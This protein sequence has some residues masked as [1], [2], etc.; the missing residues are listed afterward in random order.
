MASVLDGWRDLR[1]EIEATVPA[2]QQI[3]TIHRIVR[4][5]VEQMAESVRKMREEEIQAA[6]QMAQDAH[7]I[8]GRGDAFIDALSDG[9]ITGEE[10]GN[11]Q[12][13][14]ALLT[15]SGG[16]FGQDNALAGGVSVTGGGGGGPS[17]NPS[18]P[19]S[20]RIPSTDDAINNQTG[21]VSGWLSGIF[22]LLSKRSSPGQ[23]I[24]KNLPRPGNGE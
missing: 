6:L 9:V 2:V 17:G 3:V 7:R 22:D 16:D 12:K 4:E 15:T 19:V 13:A 21:V 18:D 11:I 10:F 14:L 20:C 23:Y 8:A 1:R 24:G 5:E